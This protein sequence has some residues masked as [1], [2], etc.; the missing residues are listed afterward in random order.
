MR[1]RLLAP[2]TSA[3]LAFSAP[4]LGSSWGS[5]S[6]RDDAPPVRFTSA[7]TQQSLES[8]AS[9]NSWTA[10]ASMATARANLTATR[11]PGASS[12]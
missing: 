9:S 7:T 10:T 1:M 3:V 12:W 6:A 11:L 2:V 8:T 4:A 5:N